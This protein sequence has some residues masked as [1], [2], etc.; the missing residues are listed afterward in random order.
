[1]ALKKNETPQVA[2]DRQVRAHAHLKDKV[3]V[4]AA[5]IDAGN[6]PHGYEWPGWDSR[7]TKKTLSGTEA[8]RLWHDPD[9]EIKVK[10]RTVKGVFRIGSPSTLTTSENEGL[11]ATAKKHIAV[12]KKISTQKN[13]NVIRELKLQLAAKEALLQ[14]VID[15]VATVGFENKKLQDK[16]VRLEAMIE[17]QNFDLN[18]A[19]NEIRALKSTSPLRPVPGH[20]G[21]NDECSR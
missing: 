2:R 4:L 14:D 15:Q 12:L 20:K 6:V 19:R 9:L 18:A 5:F 11:V 8:F 7:G 17:E 1:M 21:G 10:G 13:S 3:D 16:V